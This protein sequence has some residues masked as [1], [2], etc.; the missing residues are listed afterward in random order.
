MPARPRN[1]RGGDLETAQLALHADHVDFVA[2]GSRFTGETAP[3]V[4]IHQVRIFRRHEVAQPAAHQLDAVNTDKSRKL[5]VGVQND[6][7]V[8]E[9]RF[10]NAIAQVGEQFGRGAR[11]FALVGGGHAR[12]QVIDG[13]GEKRDFGLVALQINAPVQTPADR[14]PL[15]LLG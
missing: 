12:Q 5:T 14:Y 15:H 6:I 3:D 1:Q 7:A 9:H 10:V 13:S 2:L 8:Y 4:L 11:N